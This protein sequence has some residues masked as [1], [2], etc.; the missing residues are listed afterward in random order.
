MKRHQKKLKNR[1]TDE[2]AQIQVD[3]LQ[4]KK[5]NFTLVV[6]NCIYW[7]SNNS[8]Y[9]TNFVI[10]KKILLICGNTKLKTHGIQAKWV[11]RKN[12]NFNYIWNSNSCQY[13]FNRI[14]VSLNY[15]NLQRSACILYNHAQSHTVNTF[16]CKCFM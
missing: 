11:R 1:S 15:N 3:F 16:I 14:Y 7:L 4:L 13:S 12:S 5:R 9:H 2:S 10:V 6:F 8:L